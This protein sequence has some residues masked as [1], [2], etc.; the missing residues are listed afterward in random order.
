MHEQAGPER[1]EFLGQALVVEK[2]LTNRHRRI[3]R[4]VDR[5][6]EASLE[7]A[8]GRMQRGIGGHHALHQTGARRQEAKPD[9]STP[10]LDDERDVAESEGVGEL[11]HPGHM[12]SDRVRRSRRRLVGAPETNEVRCHR[13]QTL[14]DEPVDHFAVEVGPCRLA[15][16]Q[17][18]HFRIMRALVDVVHPQPVGQLGVVRT[19]WKARECGEPFVGCTQ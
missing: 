18:D 17:Q 4:R 10:V 6:R 7:C 1:L 19:E 14:R 12:A 2:C 15:M 3:L 9:R 16:E 11:C 8:L 5:P 13:A